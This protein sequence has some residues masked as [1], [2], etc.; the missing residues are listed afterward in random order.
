MIALRN[1]TLV[2][3]HPAEVESGMDVVIDGTEIVATGRGAAVGVHAGSTIDCAGRV[4]MPG[5]VCGHSHFYSAL[6]RGILA[7]IAPT[8]DFVSILTNLWWRLDRAIDGEILRASAMVSALDAVKAGCTAVIDH[9]ASPSFITGSLD[10][11]KGCLE[12]MGVRGVLCYET[13]DRNGLPGMEEGIAENARLAR[14][15]EDEKGGKGKDRLVEA[16]IG[17][18]APFTLPDQGLRA[19]G[20]L[21]RESGRGFHVH[22]AE[23]AFDSSFSHRYHG[24]DPLERLDEF[25]LLTDGSLVAHGVHLGERDREI[26][27]RRDAFLAHNPRSNMNNAVGYNAGLAGVKRVTLGT[28]GIGCDMLEEL[29]FAYFK[30][31]DSGGPL[32]AS[33]F[34]RM[35]AG[36]NE[37]LGRCFGESFGK[38]RK[39]FKA[40]LVVLDYDP[41]TPLE[42]VNA[43]G[44]AVFGM[45]AGQVDTVIINGKIV[46]E[47]RRFSWDTAAVYREAREAARTLWRRMDEI[48]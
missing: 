1:A 32:S 38:A 26:L 5:L 35:L 30:H 7:K 11:L 23:D 34:T 4:V 46:M 42:S 13:T 41:P 36:G 31:R 3:L 21:V 43:A 22:V 18:H 14:I 8:D 9:H 28:D 17:G 37:L 29:K 47:N 19:L 16:M 25:G 12:E 33:D 24:R 48:K 6:A 2:N 10:V 39:G 27:N 20:D 44:H 40:D 45:S 15:V